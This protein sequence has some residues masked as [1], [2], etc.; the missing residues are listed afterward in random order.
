MS[1]SEGLIKSLHRGKWNG[2]DLVIDKSRSDEHGEVFT[3]SNIV[4]DMLNL[5]SD[6]YQLSRDALPIDKTFLEPSCGTGNFLVQILERKLQLCSSLNDMYKAVSTIY[7]IDIQKDNVLESRLRMLEILEAKC[8]DEKFLSAMADVLE[9]NIVGG[10]MVADKWGC[11][12]DGKWIAGYVSN[13][14]GNIESDNISAT[15]GRIVFYKWSG[16]WDNTEKVAE[17]LY[18]DKDEEVK[19]DDKVAVESNDDLM[20]RFKNM[21]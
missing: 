8:N 13:K 2:T 6:E 15:H 1:I 17:F 12:I 18:D 16:V 9:K 11:E 5:L 10:D 3:P 20:A 14:S 21:F 7:G 19:E 4:S